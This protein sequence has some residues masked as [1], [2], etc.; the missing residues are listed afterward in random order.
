MGIADDSVCRPGSYPT[1]SS[2][3]GE[4]SLNPSS[5]SLDWAITV[6]TSEDRT[7]SLEFTVGGD[8]AGAFFPVKISFIGEGSV[9][10]IT[11]A[12]VSRVDDGEEANFSVDS[13]VNTDSYV[14]V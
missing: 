1:V 5:H 9:A 2:H 7:G 3:S 11:P 10:G 4:W 6:V 14:V 13:I 8:D 12:A